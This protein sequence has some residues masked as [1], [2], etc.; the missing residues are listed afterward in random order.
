M[1]LTL[2]ID[3]EH[4]FDSPVCTFFVVVVVVLNSL[5]EFASF[6]QR[7]SLA[8]EHLAETQL[9]TQLERE[10]SQKS[11]KSQPGREGAGGGGEREREVATISFPRRQSALLCL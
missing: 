10:R 6:T 8:S 3:N 5:S 11:L 2:A 9:S 4:T 1:T 7:F